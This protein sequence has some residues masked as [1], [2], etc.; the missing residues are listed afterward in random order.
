MSSTSKLWNW[1]SRNKWYLI[2]GVPLLSFA[3]APFPGCGMIYPITDNLRGH[4]ERRHGTQPQNLVGFWVRDESVMYDFLGQAFYLMPDGRFAGMQGMTVRRWHFD[5]N[6]LSVDSVS[7]CGNCYRGNVTTEYSVRLVDG[8]QMFVTNRDK[9]A[10]R[11][12]SGKYRR[13]EVNSALQSAMSRLQDSPNEGE[14]FKARM[15]LKA[16]EQFD[17]M[18]KLKTP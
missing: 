1:I 13:V 9:N 16:I 5:D 12:I 18:S 10:N 17:Q 15:V 7:R 3:L 14:S 2:V 4:P 11:G 8:D 6:L